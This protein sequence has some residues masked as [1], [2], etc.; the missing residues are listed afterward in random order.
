[1]LTHFDLF[2]ENIKKSYQDRERDV[3]EAACMLQLEAGELAELYLKRKWYKKD[4]TRTQLISEA[5]DIL[6]FLIF[7]LNFEKIT[8]E[9]CCENNIT[10]L[11]NRGWL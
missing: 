5:G 1:M 11:K 10:K 4:F 7:I 2:I 8:I 3:G 6:N 9:E